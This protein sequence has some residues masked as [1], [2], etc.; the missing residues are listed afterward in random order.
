[1]KTI[2]QYALGL[3]AVG[4]LMGLAP[5]AA[6]A[7]DLGKPAGEIKDGVL[8]L[9]LPQRQD[10]RI[11][12]PPLPELPAL[13]GLEL[14]A[15]PP[16]P[17]LPGLDGLPVVPGQVIRQVDQTN[18]ELSRVNEKF[19]VSQAHNGNKLTIHGKIVAGQAQI[20]CVEQC[21]RGE[22]TKL[23]MDKLTDEQRATIEKM[24]AT[25]GN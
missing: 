19:V 9:R 15:L 13:P 14:P 8:I 4:G 25:L 11:A 3:L 20:H 12:L 7:Q 10:I 17:E 21:I 1:M 24:I 6:S 18:F 16:L 5:Q 23:E 22:R 2:K